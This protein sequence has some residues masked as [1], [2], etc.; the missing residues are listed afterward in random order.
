MAWTR[1][2]KKKSWDRLMAGAGVARTPSLP[3]HFRATVEN[4]AQHTSQ[5]LLLTEQ[6]ARKSLS[7]TRRVEYTGI[8]RCPNTCKGTHKTPS[9][10]YRSEYPAD[11]PTQPKV[12][13]K[14]HAI[15]K[16]CICSAP[17]PPRGKHATPFSHGTPSTSM[18]SAHS[19]HNQWVV[20]VN[21]DR[22][23]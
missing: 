23:L 20:N 15:P 3:F 4:P 12:N 1:G 8:P 5:F 9:N 11:P 7:P 14:H 2:P 19:K 18:E 6:H 22:C 13:K 16:L 21:H 10:T 17:P